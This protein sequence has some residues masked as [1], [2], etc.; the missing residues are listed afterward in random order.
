MELTDT[1]IFIYCSMESNLH[2]VH[3]K[4]HATAEPINILIFIVLQICANINF[5]H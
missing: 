3:H 1:Y 4:I 5:Y 2:Y